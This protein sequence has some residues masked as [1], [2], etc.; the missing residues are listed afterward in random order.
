MRCVLVLALFLTACG[1]DATGSSFPPIAGTY[2]ASFV[3]SFSNSIET[4]SSSV[5]G[6]LTL[7]SP[8]SGGA[9]SGSYIITGGG[10]G[11][12]AG[13][14]RIDGGISITQFGDPNA[15]PL[16]S[17]QILQNEFYWCDFSRAAGTPM[18]GS[19]VGNTLSFSGGI[20]VPCNYVNPTQTV[21]STISVT[22]T[23]TR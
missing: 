18:N 3:V 19:V 15:D 9:F 21:P 17:L 1:G 23:G 11:T 7:H 14:I 12:I 20:S 8:S 22:V 16:E 5:P 2:S 13:T 10:S 4:E 6:T